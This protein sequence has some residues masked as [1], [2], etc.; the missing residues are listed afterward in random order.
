MQKLSI[1][2]IL[3]VLLKRQRIEECALYLVRV[4]LEPLI[5]SLSCSS[6]TAEATAYD[7]LFGCKFLHCCVNEFVMMRE[8]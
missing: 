1:P 4:P 2:D 3:A 7:L 5:G 8:S 6:R